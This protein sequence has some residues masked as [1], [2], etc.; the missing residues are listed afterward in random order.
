MLPSALRY[1]MWHILADTDCQKAAS[2]GAMFLPPP[3]KAL[4]DAGFRCT[5]YS[6]DI[7]HGNTAYGELILEQI[8][9]ILLARANMES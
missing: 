2:V 8:T 4:D 6:E 9:D 1:K 5:K 7:L 3:A